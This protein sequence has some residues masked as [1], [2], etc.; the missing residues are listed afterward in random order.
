MTTGTINEIIQRNETKHTVNFLFYKDRMH[1]Y[2]DINNRIY[3]LNR[4]LSDR[5]LHAGD[6]VLVALSDVFDSFSVFLALLGNGIS[7]ILIDPDTPKSKIQRILE[8]SKINAWFVNSKSSMAWG[9]DQLDPEI[10]GFPIDPPKKRKG[11]LVNKLLRKKSAA[12]VS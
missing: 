12:D 1:T 11:S 6:T 7:T 4:L 3:C 2:K 8:I 9:L 5:G 10:C